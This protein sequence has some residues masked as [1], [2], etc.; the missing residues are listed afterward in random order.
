MYH[1][2][3]NSRSMQ[4]RKYVCIYYYIR[5]NRFSVGLRLLISTV[6]L[7]LSEGRREEMYLGTGVTLEPQ[8]I[9]GFVGKP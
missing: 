2:C 4:I 9:Q 5:P 1:Y 8:H 7:R 3:Y 6:R